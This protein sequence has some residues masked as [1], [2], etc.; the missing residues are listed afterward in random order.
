L[1]RK[2]VGYAKKIDKLLYQER[3]FK[4]FMISRILALLQRN[5]FG[6]GVHRF[7]SAKVNLAFGGEPTAFNFTF[8][9]KVNFIAIKL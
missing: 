4:Q 1:V 8:L 5:I 2:R 6:D 7:T 3:Y 9:N